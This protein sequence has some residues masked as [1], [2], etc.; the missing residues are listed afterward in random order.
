M[1]APPHLAQ[2]VVAGQPGV[3]LVLNSQYLASFENMIF[4]AVTEL[5]NNQTLG[6]AIPPMTI[7]IPP[8][9]YPDL[10][11]IG[12]QLASLT[13]TNYRL[14]LDQFM[15]ARQIAYPQAAAAAF[16]RI[17]MRYIVNVLNIYGYIFAYHRTNGFGWQMRSPPNNNS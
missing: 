13:Q 1:I 5:Q 3:Q 8:A 16:A 7:T 14:F 2:N 15:L 10:E 6:L 4:T 17:D 11:A 9:F 12:V